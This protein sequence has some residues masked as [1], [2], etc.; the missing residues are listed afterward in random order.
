M[1][2]R[3]SDPQ[4]DLAQ[5]SRR[6]RLVESGRV[7]LDARRA[8]VGIYRGMTMVCTGG[9]AAGRVAALMVDGEAFTHVLLMCFCPAPVY[10]LVPIGAI[11]QVTEDRILLR[12]SSEVVNE[13]PTRGGGQDA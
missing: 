13:L 9:Q 11:A 12:I 7:R 3:P 2:G 8:A 5:P 6:D 10:R 4:A 1:N